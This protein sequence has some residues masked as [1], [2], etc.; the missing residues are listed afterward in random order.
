M[1]SNILKV[2]PESVI[3]F[4]IGHRV[5]EYVLR[6]S[7]PARPIL[8]RDL[9]AQR[10]HGFLHFGMKIESVLASIQE[11]KLFSPRVAQHITSDGPELDQVKHQA[12]R[13]PEWSVRDGY[14]NR[15][16]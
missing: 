15:S 4:K 16:R 3:R 11:Y 14:G 9:P 10:A 5:I 2:S 8:K 1:T 7:E 13:R 6:L 12:R